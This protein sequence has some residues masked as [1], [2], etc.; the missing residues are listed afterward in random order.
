MIRRLRACRARM[1]HTQCSACPGPG[2]GAASES[3]ATAV[4]DV[5]E[6]Q[7]SVRLR[8]APSNAPNG[9]VVRP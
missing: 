2:L 6:S 9:I 3:H 5:W 8:I 7:A 4:D 1:C